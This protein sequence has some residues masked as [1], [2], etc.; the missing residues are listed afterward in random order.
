MTGEEN[1]AAEAAVTSL[2]QS[3]RKLLQERERLQRAID[4]TAAR[5]AAASQQGRADE[6][7][8]YQA[9]QRM[10]QAFQAQVAGFNLD[11]EVL[12]LPDAAAMAAMEYHALIRYA[13][14]TQVAQLSLERLYKLLEADMDPALAGAPAR[15]GMPPAWLGMRS[16]LAAQPDWVAALT[17]FRTEYPAFRERMALTMQLIDGL[18]GRPA[19]PSRLGEAKELNVPGLRGEH[20]RLEAH[21]RRIPGGL[22]LLDET[23]FPKLEA[24]LVPAA[25]GRKRALTDTIKGLFKP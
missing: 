16:Q 9:S 12:T 23:G 20:Y 18:Q 15:A 6:A 19:G 1:K 2:A 7:A 11:G 14:A 5:A 8:Y 22:A 4:A 3:H 13:M 21:V 17:R 25:G 24:T 10:F